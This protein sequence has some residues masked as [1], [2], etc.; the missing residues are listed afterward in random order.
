MDFT[1]VCWDLRL[2]QAQPAA[3]ASTSFGRGVRSISNGAALAYASRLR[4]A[5]LLCLVFS[6]FLSL[7]SAAHCAYVLFCSRTRTRGRDVCYKEKE[8][9]FGYEIVR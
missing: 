2:A 8:K 3:E 6:F 1:H 9:D 4:V 7:F 5:F